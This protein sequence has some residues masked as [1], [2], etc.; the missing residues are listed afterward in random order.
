M[1]HSESERR[2]EGD[3]GT[4]TKRRGR[5]R[6]ADVKSDKQTDQDVKVGQGENRQGSKNRSDILSCIVLCFSL[7]RMFLS[8]VKCLCFA[9]GWADVHSNII[10]SLIKALH[11]A[12][13]LVAK[14]YALRGKRPKVHC[15]GVC[16]KNT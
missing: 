15:I 16:N 14:Q 2:T 6:T 1:L 10:A 4:T 5:Q 13:P 3:K 12:P 9:G 8:I 7:L 11:M